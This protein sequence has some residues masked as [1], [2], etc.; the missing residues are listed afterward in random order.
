MVERGVPTFEGQLRLQNE[1]IVDIERRLRVP[2]GHPA[3]EALAEAAVASGHLWITVAANDTPEPHKS[4]ADFICDG[5]NDQEEIQAALDLSA[6][7]TGGGGATMYS[8]VYLFEGTFLLSAGV[9]SPPPGTIPGM[10]LMGSGF[11]TVIKRANSSSIGSMIT[12]LTFSSISHLTFDGNKANNATTTT[13][14]DIGDHSTVF[15]CWFFDTRGGAIDMDHSCTVDICRF[16]AQQNLGGPVLTITGS[17][18]PNDVSRIVNSWFDDTGGILAPGRG[19]IVQ[20]CSF[21]RS[22]RSGIAAGNSLS[23]FLISGNKFIQSSQTT[24]DTY[25]HINLSAVSGQPT[26]GLITANL[27]RKNNAAAS[28]A[29]YCVVVPSGATDIAIIGNDFRDGFV[30]GDVSDAGTATVIHDNP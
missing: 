12:M 26:L 21:R 5:T 8:P 13:S 11:R 3:L 7:L 24:N 9:V 28:N 16:S 15:D 1:R 10:T 2:H 14:L 25:P 30:T 4:S 22:H 17:S 19:L 18:D 23:D 20:G 27:F 29:N 6:S